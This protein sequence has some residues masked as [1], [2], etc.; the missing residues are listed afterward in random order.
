MTFTPGPCSRVER[1]RAR[2]MTR[3]GRASLLGMALLVAGTDSSTA[4]STVA[5]PP[6]TAKPARAAG[7]LEDLPVNTFVALELPAL[8]QGIPGHGMKHVT[9]AYTPI[10]KRLYA[11]GGDYAGEA[12]QQSYRQE[13]WSLSLAGRWTK[14]EE[15]AAGW[16]LEYPY[17]GPADQVQPKHPDFVG[18][19]WDAKRRLFWMMPGTMVASNDT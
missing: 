11:V 12:Y 3:W 9:W 19:M 10:N 5:S 14:R 8:G 15:P 2:S 18:W 7:V 6:P 4:S 13:V 17:C 1:P 16:R